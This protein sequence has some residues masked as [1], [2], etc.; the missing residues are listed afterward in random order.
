[1]M[2]RIVF[3]DIEKTLADFLTAKL[4]AVSD[5]AVVVMKVP[6]TRPA[7]MVRVTRN[8][9]KA[10]LDVE[11]REGRRGAQLVL[12]RPRVVFEC[13]DDAGNAA[14]LAALVR[15][16]VNAAAP[17]RIGT[18]WCDY[19]EDAGE[20]NDTDPV[21]AA[22]RYTVVTDLIVRGTVLA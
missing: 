12:D 15:G 3:S 7:R 21:T 4:A 16:I 10:R 20:E 19:V 18:V 5:G 8:D 17:G 1:M 9:R 11:D 14:G 6:E 13:S 22:P 2:E